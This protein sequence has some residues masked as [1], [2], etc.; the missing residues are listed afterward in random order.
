[1]ASLLFTLTAV[2]FAIPAFAEGEPSSPE[3]SAVGGVS[4]EEAL[5]LE[6]L[7]YV[8]YSPDVANLDKSWSVWG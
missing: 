1:M 4:K 6:A 7:G 2:A 8:D 5:R 3:A